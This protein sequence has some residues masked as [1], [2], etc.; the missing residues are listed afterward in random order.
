MNTMENRTL[1]IILCCLWG[2]LAPCLSQIE[3]ET[4]YFFKQLSLQDGISQTTVQCVLCDYKGQIWTGTRYGLNRFDREEMTQYLHKSTDTLSLPHNEVHF[5]IEDA[6]LNIWVGTENGVVRHN[7]RHDNF[8]PALLPDGRKMEAQSC[9][10]TDEGVYFG[11]YGEFFFYSYREKQIVPLPVKPQEK[12]GGY[13]RRICRYDSHLLLASTRWDGTWLY[14]LHSHTLH[15]CPFIPERDILALLIDSHEVIWV[16]PYGKG[17]Y[18]YSRSGKLLHH[19]TAENSELKNNIVLDI[20]EKDGRLW[21]ATDG[22][23]LSILDLETQAIH[24]IQHMPGD[25]HSLPV[26]SLYCLYSDN[27]NNIWAGSIR[28]GL[29]GIKQV[30]FQS[31]GDAPL[32]TPYGLSEKT[33]ASLCEDADSI[34]WVGTDGGGVNRF[35]PATRTF[36][37]Y[38]STY[39]EKVVSLVD[40]NR[41]ELLLS[42]FGKGLY[43][44]NKQTGQT[45]SL[46]FRSPEENDRLFKNGTSVN[47]VRLSDRLFYL[48]G[49]KTYLFDAEQQTFTEAAFPDNQMGDLALLPVGTVADTTYLLSPYQLLALSHADNTIRP[50]L[51]SDA[52]TKGFNSA[53]R[54]PDG[55]FWIGSA[56]GLFHY[57]PAAKELK[58]IPTKLFDNI[59]SLRMDTYGRLWI[60]TPRQL[61]VYLPQK[62]DFVMFGESDGV[63]ANEYLAKPTLL[64]RK[65][66]VY[67]GGVNGLLAIRKD[68]P[69]HEYPEPDIRL[70]DVVVDGA[71]VGYDMAPTNNALTVPWNHTSLG[72]KVIAKENDLLRKKIFRFRVEGLS[73]EYI[74]MH[75]HTLTL[76]SLPVNDYTIWVSCN[77]KDGSWSTPVQV[78]SVTVMPP[79][80]KSVW[81]LSLVVL[82]LLGSIS[83]FVYLGFKQKEDR[84]KLEMKE[85]ERKTYEEKIRFLINISHELRTPLTL[86]YAPLKRLLRSGKVKEPEL[87][88]QLGTVYKQAWQMRNLINMVLNV[89]K[90][91]VGQDVVNISNH[92]LHEWIYFVADD[93]TTELETKDVKLAYDFDP[94]I[95]HLPF[96]DAKC[97]IILSNLLMNAL[98]FSK[99]GTEIT[100]STRRLNGYVRIAVADQGIGLENVDISRLFTRFYRGN[101]DRDGSGIGLSYSRML[102]E[103]QNGRMNAFDNPGKGATFFFELPETNRLGETSSEIRPYLNELLFVPE[104]NAAPAAPVFDLSKYTVLVVEDEPDLRNYLKDTL[105]EDFKHVY[106]AEDGLR[107]L[108]VIRQRHPDI[109]V[110]DI[111]MPRMNGYEMCKRVKEDVEISHIPVILLTARS[112]NDSMTTGYKLGA[113]VYLPK[114]FDIDFLMTVLRNQIKNREFIKQEYKKNAPQVIPQETTFSNADEKFIL[115]LNK[116]IIDNLNTLDLD[117]NFLTDKMAMSRASLYNKMKA[118]TDMGVNDYINKF[119]MEKAVQLLTATQLSIL[120][121]SEQC[122]FSSQ[123]YFSTLFKQVYGTTPTKYRQEKQKVD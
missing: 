24:T 81:F 51:W 114:P 21:L 61:F 116:L 97:E 69:F 56:T 53:L 71:S 93:F 59:N 57:L 44:F 70:L 88:R 86:I 6:L 85:H 63:Y 25:S 38:A 122:G 54:A 64:S 15:R 37:H 104:E 58:A 98:K 20:L 5:C 113:D 2:C 48:V 83:A 80:W 79:W 29:I 1:H 46:L 99:P 118:V 47:L 123:R 23:G 74:E 87:H 4:E 89:R 8:L 17:L 68:I 62:E 11:G 14:N 90:M 3:G 27:E 42:C 103:L 72:V 33:V 41:H 28:G 82:V 75:N 95:T 12:P 39:G 18:A 111:M 19:F 102:A 43:A 119:R 65:G 26:N 100:V 22:G 73:E 120:E 92:N 94:E 45:R 13:F 50:L 115:K 40:F 106:V 110:S 32:N 109:I 105:A 35:D 67:I 84:L 78:L 101:H 55:S 76:R 66:N 107:A 31:Y 49:N 9:F 7:R 30:Y 16:S 112:D 91:E 96:D 36:R 34:V 117:V 52:A 108:E 121:I 60:G 77:K 10:Q